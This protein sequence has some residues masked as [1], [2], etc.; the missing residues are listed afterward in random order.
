MHT[1]TLVVLRFCW[2]F[3][4]SCSLVTQPPQG[5]LRNV[6]TVQ[7]NRFAT[8]HFLS[9]NMDI[10]FFSLS[11]FLCAWIVFGLFA[12]LRSVQLLTVSRDQS[13]RY[14]SVG[15][16]TSPLRTPVRFLFCRPQTY[17]SRAPT[18]VPEIE[19]LVFVVGVV[20]VG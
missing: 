1:C 7:E 6:L 8:S 12:E 5:T 10:I 14:C 19:L 13:L 18:T 4:V 3:S 9:K 17:M 11:L 15:L 20:C 2:F 16:C